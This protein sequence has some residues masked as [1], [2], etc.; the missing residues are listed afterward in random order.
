MEKVFRLVFLPFT[1]RHCGKI[2]Y[3]YIVF[4]LAI[5]WSMAYW[6]FY[7]RHAYYDEFNVATFTYHKNNP[8]MADFDPHQM[9]LDYFRKKA[10]QPEILVE[11]LR[12]GKVEKVQ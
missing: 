3:V 8:V 2:N 7:W 11:D 6:V 1:C 12:T 9:I 4:F 10:R 5:F